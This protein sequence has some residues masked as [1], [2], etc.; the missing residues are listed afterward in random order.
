MR[1]TLGAHLDLDQ[2]DT[3]DALQKAG[4]W[5]GHFIV[6]SGSGT[7][8]TENGTLPVLVGPAAAMMRQIAFEVLTAYGN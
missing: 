4:S 1:N 8:S 5:G 7:L 3:L 2:V 6:G